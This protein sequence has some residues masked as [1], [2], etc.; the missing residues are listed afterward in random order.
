MRP[1]IVLPAEALAT[2]AVGRAMLSA[3]LLSMLASMTRVCGASASRLAHD[4]DTRR[5]RAMVA[6]R[7]LHQRFGDD[8]PLQRTCS[9]HA[10]RAAAAYRGGCWGKPSFAGVHA[11]VIARVL[12]KR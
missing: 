3:R 2:K 10:G 1:P 7:V 4:H 8:E 6:M 5:L 11:L 9:G 12:K